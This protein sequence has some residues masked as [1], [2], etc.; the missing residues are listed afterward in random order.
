MTME[1]NKPI[2]LTPPFN[3]F[4]DRSAPSHPPMTQE[5]IKAFL[6]ATQV[7]SDPSHPKT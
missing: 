3:R 5:Q 2:H 6:E 4:V 7:R 1:N